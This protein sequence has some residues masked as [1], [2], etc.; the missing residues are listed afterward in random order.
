MVSNTTGNN[1]WE[2]CILLDFNFLGLSEMYIYLSSTKP[3][4]YSRLPHMHTVTVRLGAPDSGGNYQKKERK[5][6]EPR[7]PRKLDPTIN[8]NFTVHRT[9]LKTRVSLKCKMYD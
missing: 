9:F 6:G 8:D 4:I 2:N 1:Q 7:N 3:E 5:K